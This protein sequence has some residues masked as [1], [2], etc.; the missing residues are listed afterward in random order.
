MIEPKEGMYSEAELATI[1]ETLGLP[2]LPDEIEATLCNAAAPYLFLA[3]I[4]GEL[5]HIAPLTPDQRSRKRALKKLQNY[6]EKLKAALEDQSAYWPVDGAQLFDL[7]NPDYS[8]CA[9][10]GLVSVD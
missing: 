7:L 9:V 10:K 5:P 1:A 6:T 4:S 2:R 3:D 8:R